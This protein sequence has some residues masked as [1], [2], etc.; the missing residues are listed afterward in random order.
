MRTVACWWRSRPNETIQ[1]QIA[2]SRDL[3]RLL[4]EPGLP[5][6][7]PTQETSL[8]SL[9]DADGRA[10]HMG[11]CRRRCWPRP[12]SLQGRLGA[13]GGFLN[14]PCHHTRGACWW[15]VVRPGC[16]EAAQRIQGC[17]RPRYKAVAIAL[18]VA[19]V[20]AGTLGIDVGHAQGQALTEPQAQ[21]VHGKEEHAVAQGAGG[22]WRQTGSGP[23]AP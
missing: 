7:S 17:Y 15:P 23:A 8:R 6:R 19:N 3:I 22:G 12:P 4:D 21:A 5:C 2:R 14:E 11:G 18:G 10:A 1:G 9:A 16:P 13:D 20:H